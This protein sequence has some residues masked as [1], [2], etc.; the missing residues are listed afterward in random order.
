MFFLNNFGYKSMVVDKRAKYVFLCK[1]KM[2]FNIN[3]CAYFE[4]NLEHCKIETLGLGGRDRMASIPLNQIPILIRHA[5]RL[6]I[7]F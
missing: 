7:M 4:T 5:I 2:I 3:Q 6:L 1:L